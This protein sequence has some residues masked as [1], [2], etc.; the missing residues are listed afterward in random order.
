MFEL[1]GSVDWGVICALLSVLL[2]C[3]GLG[4]VT[5]YDPCDAEE[6]G[7]FVP[8][9]EC[10]EEGSRI[11]AGF[12]VKKGLDIETLADTAAIDAAI[13]AGTLKPLRDLEGNWAKGTSNKKPGKGFR[14][15]KHSTWTFAIP[16]T[17]YGVDANLKFWNGVSNQNEWS[18]LF[19]FEDFSIWGALDRDKQ[20]ILMDIVAD[21]ESTS[22]LGGQ[23]QI[24]GMATWTSKDLPYP[25]LAPAIAGFTKSELRTRFY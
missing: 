13:V 7:A 1:L 6:V 15:E 17:H 2:A 23:R 25:L 14:R 21:P 12:L 24:S 10:V 9:G 3:A 19:I 20:P 22:E 16:F 4:A 5:A 11:L 18:M 8:E